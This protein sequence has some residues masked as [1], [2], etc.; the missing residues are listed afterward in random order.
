[1]VIA[2]DESLSV[3]SSFSF[4]TTPDSVDVDNAYTP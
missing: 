3:S 1:M 4:R 2:A